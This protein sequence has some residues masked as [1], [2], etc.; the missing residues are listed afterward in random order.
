MSLSI[1]L[2]NATKEELI[3]LPGI[4]PKMADRILAYRKRH[5]FFKRKKDLMRIKGIG[6][7]KFRKIESY[8]K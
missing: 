5:G 3:R 7:K 8:L 6:L 2:N 4:G 1:D